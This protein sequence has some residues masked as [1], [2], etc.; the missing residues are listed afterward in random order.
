MERSCTHG[1]PQGRLREESGGM[2]CVFHVGNGDCGIVDSVVDDSVD[3][4]GDRILG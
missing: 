2:M 4:H 3:G 1:I